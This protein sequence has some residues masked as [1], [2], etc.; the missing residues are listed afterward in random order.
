MEIFNLDQ[1]NLNFLFYFF[2]KDRVKGLGFKLGF[3]RKFEKLGFL[4]FHH[5]T[6]V[7]GASSPIEFE[8]FCA[9]GEPAPISLAY[10][11]GKK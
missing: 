11:H 7:V 1:E 9:L 10:H 5:G 4:S 6:S 2:A 3:R 8:C